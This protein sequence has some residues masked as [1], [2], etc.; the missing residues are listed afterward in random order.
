MLFPEGICPC[1]VTVLTAA[2]CCTTLD[3][4][5]YIHGI[6]VTIGKGQLVTDTDSLG[7]GWDTGS[8]ASVVAAGRPRQLHISAD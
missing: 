5:W 3:P 4:L 6:L 8:C 2:H 1:L 7:G